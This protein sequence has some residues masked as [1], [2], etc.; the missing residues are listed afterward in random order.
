MNL[1]KRNGVFNDQE[2]SLAKM[3]GVKL[4]AERNMVRNTPLTYDIDTIDVAL[5]EVGH[6]TSNIVHAPLPVTAKVIRE[7]K[8]T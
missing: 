6:K 3:D 2:L 5:G 1:D 8:S 4:I 7:V